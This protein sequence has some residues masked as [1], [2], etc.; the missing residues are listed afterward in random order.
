M[1]VKLFVRDGCPD[2]PEALR[3][4]AA[5]T[6]LSVYNLS[7]MAGVAEASIWGVQSA[8]SVVVV[9]SDGHQLAAWRGTA[10]DVSELRAILAN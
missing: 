6:E 7:D 8:P 10:P 3:A 5:A 9:N 4:C 2:C 1:E